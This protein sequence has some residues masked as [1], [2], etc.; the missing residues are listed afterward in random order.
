MGVSE[1][2]I[3]PFKKTGLGT[4]A[5]AYLMYKVISPL[6][7]IITIVGTQFIVKILRQRGYMKPVAESEKV[8][9]LLK[10]GIRE[11]RDEIKARIRERAKFSTLRKRIMKPPPA[12]Q[13]QIKKE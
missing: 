11:T 1:I 9:E 12:N 8:R 5:I 6:R 2:I 13:N 7:Y 10:E 3:S 4:L